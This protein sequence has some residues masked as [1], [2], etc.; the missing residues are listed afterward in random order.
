MLKAA[1]YVLIRLAVDI[2][3]AGRD[4]VNLDSAVP[5][6]AAFVRLVRLDRPIFS[7]TRYRKSGRLNPRLFEYI[8]D[9]DRS[10]GR[11][12]PVT[13]MPGK[14]AGLENGEV[15]RMTDDLYIKA[16]R[17]SGV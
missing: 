6:I 3:L 2:N 17:D 9:R 8:F 4:D 14:C 13:R 16:F 1:H 12:V 11:K 5:R 10:M 7:H 15:V